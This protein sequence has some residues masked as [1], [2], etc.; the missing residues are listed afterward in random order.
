MRAENFV[1]SAAPSARPAR[2]TRGTVTRAVI[3]SNAATQA[4]MNSAAPMSVVTTWPW[5]ST[6]GLVTVSSRPSA[7]AGKPHNVRVHRNTIVARA[8]ARSRTI[9]RPR[10]SSRSPSFQR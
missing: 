3:R 8:A 1:A 10:S 7:A 5:A 9:A 2:R 6:S 4:K